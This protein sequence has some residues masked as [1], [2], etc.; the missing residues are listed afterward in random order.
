MLF[1]LAKDLEDNPKLGG[2]NL[3]W[4]R[5]GILPAELPLVAEDR[6]AWRSQLQL[7]P[8]QAQKFKGKSTKLI[9]YFP[10]K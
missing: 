7:L 6:D 2:I 9:H 1:Q 5:L 4:F 3:A 10:Q 8:A